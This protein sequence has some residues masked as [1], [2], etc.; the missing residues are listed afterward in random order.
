MD[1]DQ[2]LVSRWALF[3]LAKLHIFFRNHWNRL[4]WSSRLVLHFLRKCPCNTA[5]TTHR[6]DFINPLA[7]K[8]CLFPKGKA[9][10]ESESC[11]ALHL[12]A[13][14]SEFWRGGDTIIKLCNL[15]HREQPGSH[16]C[17]KD[18]ASFSS[19]GLQLQ[20]WEILFHVQKRRP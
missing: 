9:V 11:H 13:F 20:G 19:A 10:S 7:K 14:V 15:P 4:R 17:P 18:I 2:D 3:L 8:Y 1:V 6:R 5:T 12:Q 16:V